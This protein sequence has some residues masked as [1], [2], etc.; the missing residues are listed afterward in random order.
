MFSM[1]INTDEIDDIELSDIRDE[2]NEITLS[3]WY[4]TMFDLHQHI[5]AHCDGYR[6]AG[7]EDNDW[8]RRTGGKI[9][10]LK[11]G[12]RRIEARMLTLGFTPPYQPTDPRA[13]EIRQL[14]KI[15]KEL[16]GQLA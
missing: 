14:L 15:N 6:E 3:R 12:M 16:R 7:I 5:K 13:I 9:A 8:F 1:T 11:L 4:Q 10:Y 2:T